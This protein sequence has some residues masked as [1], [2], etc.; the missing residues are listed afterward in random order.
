[1]KTIH[2][3]LVMCVLLAAATTSGCGDGVGNDGD[4]IGGACTDSADC[5]ER[6]QTG[7]DFPQGVCTISC[8]SDD[9]CPD[10]THCIDK[11]GGMCLLACTVPSDCR[12]G[13]NCE[14]KENAGHGGD[15]LVCIGD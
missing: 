15:S 12:G 6:C 7:G 5:E 8:N 10:D 4:F 11:E 13:Y 3:V 2:R 9:D 14:G 1:M